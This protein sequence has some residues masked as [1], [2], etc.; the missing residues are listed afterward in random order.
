MSDVNKRFDLTGMIFNRLAVIEY[1]GYKKDNSYVW[2]CLCSCG[3][4]HFANS[5]HLKRG[6]V[7]SCGCLQYEPNK[8]KGRPFKG[9]DLSGKQ[10][11]KLTVIRYSYSDKHHH[12][13]WECLCEC[14][15]TCYIE[16]GSLNQGHN[17]SCGCMGYRSGNR[18]GE[19]VYNY[20]GYKDIT[21]SRWNSIVGNA[22]ARNLYFEISKEQVWNVFEKQGRKCYFTN[23]PLSFLDSTASVDRLDSSIGYV[24]ENIAI[25]H[26]DINR[27][28]HNFSEEYFVY[29]CKQVYENY[30]KTKEQREAL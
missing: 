16:T 19:Q 11:G 6:A 5:K 10:F 18:R 25:V 15:N 3:K 29:L 7:K 26:K 24:E 20:K 22:K 23:L 13:R 17:M 9:E 30:G 8:A 12:R 14:G 27:I 2:R 21:G 28:K 1:A 4:E